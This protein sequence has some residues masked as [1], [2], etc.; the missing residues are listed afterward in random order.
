MQ[1]RFVSGRFTPL[2]L[3]GVSVLMWLVGI[4]VDRPVNDACI[5][6]LQI[7]NVVSRG[8]T[9]ACFAL[10]T[11]MMSSWYIFDRRIRWF[12]PLTFFLSSVSL[13][14]HGT[15]EPSFSLLLVQL[16]LYRLFLCNQG[17]DNRYG[18][19]TAFMLLGL[20]AIIVPSCIM[21]LFPF[22]LYVVMMSLVRVKEL[23]AILLGLLT[24][25]WFLF[26]IGYI[27]PDMKLLNGAEAAPWGYIAS[28]MLQM[29]TLYD[30]L[31][32]I[33]ELLVAIPFLLFLYNSSSPGK[34]VLRKRLRFFALFN[35]YLILLSLLYNHDFVLYYVWS[36]PAMGVMLT[37]IFSLNITRLSRF[38]FVA[39]SLLWLAFIPFSLWLRH[40]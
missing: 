17:E 23:F 33:V 24:P 10:A 2:I 29:P 5:Y 35:L 40:L 13:F 14:V 28:A 11:A 12:L 30:T 38:Y 1:R 7:G 26:A 37:Y 39:L 8:I 16:V 4:F 18:L 6:G 9:F 31:I 27:F 3:L 22:V 25:Y 32:I 36:L 34:P 21:L 15:V 20:A 19:F